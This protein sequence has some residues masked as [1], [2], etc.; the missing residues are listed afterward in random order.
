MSIS[1]GGV[2]GCLGT[3]PRCN[4]VTIVAGERKRARRWIATHEAN[5]DATALCRGQS[6]QSALF[7]DGVKAQCCCPH[8]GLKYTNTQI[9]AEQHGQ[10][11]L[12]DSAGSASQAPSPF[13]DLVDF[14]MNDLAL[15]PDHLFPARMFAMP[16][17]ELPTPSDGT[18]LQ[19][20]V[21]QQQDAHH[22]NLDTDTAPAP[23]TDDLKSTEPVLITPSSTQ[24]CS[25][26]ALRR[27]DLQS[28]LGAPAFDMGWP[29]DDSQC[30]KEGNTAS[31]AS[32]HL[33][34]PE[35]D[36]SAVRNKARWLMSVQ[37]LTVFNM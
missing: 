12:E 10:V 20:P 24:G 3:K 4:L 17:Q 9:E 29:A 14:D 13:T 33:S 26:C 31:S 16:Q 23:L 19:H 5:N 15:S 11:D 37:K 8:V 30:G 32:V 28:C 25:P 1:D 36:D 6:T 35:S 34:D 27:D 18:G 22:G 21:D 2:S 7:T